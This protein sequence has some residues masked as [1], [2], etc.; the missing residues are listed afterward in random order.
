MAI[1]TFSAQMGCKQSSEE[2]LPYFW[3]LKEAAKEIDISGFP[4]PELAYILRVDGN[5]WAFGV[6]GPNNFKLD[7]KGQYLSI[8]LGVTI[9]DRKRLPTVLAE[10]L[11][12]SIDALH[13]FE[14]KRKRAWHIDY[15]ELKL[16]IHTLVRNFQ[17]EPTAIAPN[18]RSK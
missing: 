1:I 5:I 12:V 18:L 3:G 7:R 11:L 6:S 17:A 9:D 14:F 10:S 4:F 8:D 16:A 13:A 2:A 15:E